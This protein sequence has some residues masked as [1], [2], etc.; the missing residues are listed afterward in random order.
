MLKQ[1]D[2]FKDGKTGRM[3]TV[4]AVDQDSIILELQDGSHQVMP[5]PSKPKT[6]LRTLVGDRLTMLTALPSPF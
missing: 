4:T 2:K 1:G 6:L 5:N 3:Y